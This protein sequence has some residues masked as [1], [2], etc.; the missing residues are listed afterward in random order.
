M[1]ASAESRPVDDMRRGYEADSANAALMRRAGSQPGGASQHTRRCAA[2]KDASN[3]IR[4]FS[5]QI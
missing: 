4:M 2:H 1:P 5:R 3:G